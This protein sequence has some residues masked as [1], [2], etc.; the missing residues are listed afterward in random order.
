MQVLNF[1]RSKS[2]LVIISRLTDDKIIGTQISRFA[3]GKLSIFQFITWN[4]FQH[5]DSLDQKIFAHL[6]R[7]KKIEFWVQFSRHVFHGVLSKFCK[8]KFSIRPSQESH[9]RK[10]KAR[11]RIHFLNNF[12]IIYFSGS[13]SFKKLET[14]TSLHFSKLRSQMYVWA[15]PNGHAL[16]HTDCPNT[17]GYVIRWPFPFGDS[18]SRTRRRQECSSSWMTLSRESG[19]DNRGVR[20]SVL[21]M[22]KESTSLKTSLS[23]RCIAITRWVMWRKLGRVRVALAGKV[24]GSLYSRN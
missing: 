11:L 3:S 19:R 24:A 7:L 10:F 13:C 5:V 21:G 18:R 4:I 9:F 22:E 23:I 17:K 15:T 20:M 6:H 12:I 14:G 8:Q 2:L 1:I 16:V